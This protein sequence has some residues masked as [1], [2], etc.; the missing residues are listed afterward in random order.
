MNELITFCH[1]TP[2]LHLAFPLRLPWRECRA[3]RQV[4]A[5]G[6]SECCS[7]P[8][9]GKDFPCSILG[10]T[11]SQDSA[12]HQPVSG[13]AGLEGRENLFNLPTRISDGKKIRH[14][15]LIDI[16]PKCLVFKL[17]FHRDGRKVKSV[18]LWHDHSLTQAPLNDPMRIF[19]PPQTNVALHS[20]DPFIVRER[21]REFGIRPDLRP[22]QRPG[23]VQGIP[24][25]VAE[26]LI[27]QHRRYFWGRFQYATLHFGQTEGSCSASPRGIHSWSHR[28]Q[29]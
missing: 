3:G 13:R 1:T 16:V 19:V 12:E 5:G 22:R 28:S 21:L 10:D 27:H 20:M 2:R 7:L 29:R 8:A 9:V 4:A 17:L 26:V 14:A 18:G 11:C 23:F 6:H 15:P 24:Y 25:L